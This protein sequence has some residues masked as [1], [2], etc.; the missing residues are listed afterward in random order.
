M[1]QQIE[2]CRRLYREAALKYAERG[3]PIRDVAIAA[4][5]SAHDLAMHSGLNAHDAIE[6]LRT[7]TDVME[8]QILEG[9]HH[10]HA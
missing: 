10:G 6:W 3:V 2:I 8:R 5:F 9:Q 7:A 1:E 4:I